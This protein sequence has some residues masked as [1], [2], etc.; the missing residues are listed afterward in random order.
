MSDAKNADTDMPDE[1]LALSS[2]DLNHIIFVFK[3]AFSAGLVDADD[4]LA[5]GTTFNKIKNIITEVNKKA[6]ET[7]NKK[8]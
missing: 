2:F 4:A 8:T 5:V 7:T 6:Q 3:K 1:R